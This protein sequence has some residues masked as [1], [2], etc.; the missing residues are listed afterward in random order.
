[1]SPPPPPGNDRNGTPFLKVPVEIEGFEVQ[2]VADGWKVCGWI[3]T[4][5]IGRVPICRTITDDEATGFFRKAIE[6]AAG[7]YERYRQRGGF[8]GWWRRYILRKK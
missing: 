1:M 7:E 2:R 6:D 8:R 5:G 3:E 4:P